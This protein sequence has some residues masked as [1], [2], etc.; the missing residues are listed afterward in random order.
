[1][2][3]VLDTNVFVSGVF[4]SGPPCDI[5]NAWR[6]GKVRLVLS[7]EILEEYRR[8]GEELARRFKN[9]TCICP[10]NARMPECREC[11]QLKPPQNDRP[12]LIFLRS[13]R[14]TPVYFQLV[15]ATGLEPVTSRPELR[16]VSK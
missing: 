14:S 4:F 11:A 5:L 12:A 13:R 15:G 8:T 3:I 6:S 9:N 7:A 16:D 2:R 10:P 1:M